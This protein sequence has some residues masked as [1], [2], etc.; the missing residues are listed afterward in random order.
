MPVPGA[1]VQNFKTHYVIA[2]MTSVANP[3]SVVV[4]YVHILASVHWVALAWE[5][6][7]LFQKAVILRD[8]TSDIVTGIYGY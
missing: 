5:M 8:D 2:R 4:K 1:R 7:N 3:E 6:V